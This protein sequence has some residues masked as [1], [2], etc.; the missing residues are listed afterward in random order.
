MVHT[1]MAGWKQ[2]KVLIC[3]HTGIYLKFPPKKPPDL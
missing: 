3:L 2:N 1:G